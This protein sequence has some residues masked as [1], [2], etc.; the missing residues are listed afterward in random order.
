MR[1]APCMG[2]L[3]AL[4]A[5]APA[6]AHGMDYPRFAFATNGGDDTLTMF[7]VDPETGWLAHN[8]YVP[9]GINPRTAVVDPQSRFVYAVNQGSSSVSAFTIDPLDGT[10]AP[11]VGSPFAAG[12]SPIA[13]AMTP[14]G[15]H[16]FVANFGDNSITRYS[17]DPVSGALTPI[18]P[19]TPACA[20][21]AAVVI[22][23]FGRYLF[24]ACSGDARVQ[25]FRIQ[26]GQLTSI[27]TWSTGVM[28][29]ALS[30]DPAARYLTVANAV[31]NSVSVFALNKLGALT[32]VPGSPFAT[33]QMPLAVTNDP[34]GRFVYAANFATSDVSV[35]ARTS[36]GSLVPRGVFATGGFPRSVDVDPAGYALYVTSSLDNEV[37]VHPIYPLTGEL[38]TPWTTR[39]RVAPSG[40]ALTKASSPATTD[41]DLLYVTTGSNVRG[42][43]IEPGGAL[44]S[45]SSLS[46]TGGALSFVADWAGRFGYLTYPL[47]DRIDAFAINPFDATLAF[48]AQSVTGDLPGVLEIDRARRFAYVSNISSEDVTRYTIDPFTGAATLAQLSF[49]P[50]V[51]AG[52]TLSDGTVDVTGRFFYLP[53]FDNGF[54]WVLSHTI[55]ETT[56]ALAQ[57]ASVNLFGALDAKLESH[58]TGKFAFTVINGGVGADIRPH[59]VDASTGAITLLQSKTVVGPELTDIA[60]DPSGRF[61]FAVGRIG[62]MT[63]GSY[64]VYAY[65]IDETTGYL[66]N[67]LGAPILLGPCGL[68]LN[69][70]LDDVAR[71]VVDPSGR[72]VYVS[73]E[74]ASVVHR[75]AIQ[76][77]GAL[78]HLGSDAV[79]AQPTWLSATP[80]RRAMT[81]SEQLSNGDFESGTASWTQSAA[82]GHSIIG[83]YGRSS[84][85]GALLGSYNGASDTLEQQV[86]IPASAETATLSGWWRITSSENS[87]VPNDLL[88]VDIRHTSGV[89]LDTIHLVGSSDPRLAWYRFAAD[90]SPYRG[91]T[92]RIHA[93]ATT[94]PAWETSFYLDDLSVETCQ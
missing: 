53:V 82:D 24:V 36:S 33:G 91:Q 14:S 2:A 20:M 15:T 46:V 32:P 76:P 50:A 47:A 65:P 3:L 78:Q 1:Y 37:L 8:G 59:R 13:L 11:V 92:I 44:T 75:L 61:L 6:A 73:L 84:A 60:V 35:Y 87:V 18:A 5:L 81:C 17:V 55:D 72:Y 39:A 71:L 52:A 42:Y 19:A 64:Y 27:G 85:S 83:P 69:D 45:R 12:A 58:P 67:A 48:T 9:T 40:L 25:G 34:S 94:D 7:V 70:C 93:R 10:L 22:E 57:S 31:S 28:P 90:L 51:S 30:F 41:P 43:H 21:P 23:P 89:L 86:T 29:A 62:V 4:A 77:T 66:G 26:A 49:K 74:Y 16:A 80:K 88:H 38:D 68:F 63:N 54:P 56:G 79:G